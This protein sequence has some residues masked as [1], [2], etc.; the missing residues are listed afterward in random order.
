MPDGG[1]KYTTPVVADFVP[2]Q[3]WVGIGAHAVNHTEQT[4]TG[5]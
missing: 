4:G 1:D 2:A 5:V 3:W